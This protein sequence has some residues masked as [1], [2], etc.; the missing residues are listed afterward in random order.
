MPVEIEPLWHL[1]SPKWAI[2]VGLSL[3]LT[4]A[5][6][7][8]HVLQS[9]PNASRDRI[10]PRIAFLAEILVSVGIIGLVT[11]AARVKIDSDIRHA[12][13]QVNE[14][15]R[16]MRVEMLNFFM[17]H[18]LPISP[19]Q[20]E[21]DQPA[22]N[23][24]CNL[25]VSLMNAGDAK[26]IDQSQDFVDWWG[27][28]DDFNKIA[29]QSKSSPELFNK[30]TLI[31][32]KISTVIQSENIADRDLH[33]KGLVE[34]EVSWS[35]IAASALLAMIGIGLKWTR[36]YLEIKRPVEKLVI[37]KTKNR[38]QGI[39]LKSR[40]LR[41]KNWSGTSVKMTKLHKDKTP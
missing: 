16:L 8:Y 13:K 39:M 7:S 22:V 32:Q 1:A 34:S 17:Q 31:S 37:E 40:Q 2:F 11:F 26:F 4:T 29:I 3:I 18:C 9:L 21:Q 6:L 24:G 27:A 23:H 28:K 38:H 10:K 12:Q 41:K 15:R 36:A 30:L 14:N 25:S 35:L 5:I 33:K 19:Q 20:K